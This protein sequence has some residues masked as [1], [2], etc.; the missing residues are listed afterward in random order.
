MRIGIMQCMKIVSLTRK[1]QITI[2][3]E[4]VR[5]LSFSSSRKIMIERHGE[6]LTLVPQKDFA[7][8]VA[9]IQDAARP[10]VKRALT[11]Q[12]LKQARAEAWT[13][14]AHKAHK[15][16]QKVKPSVSGSR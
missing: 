10:F 3:V 8:A 9:D 11:N 14:R 1:N 5:A 16:P 15:Q 7:T 13:I 12:E 4:Y 2:P 6:Y